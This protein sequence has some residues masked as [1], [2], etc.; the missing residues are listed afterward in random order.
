[1]NAMELN[2]APLQS[3]SVRTAPNGPS[4][5]EVHGFRERAI[6]NGYP[7]IRVRSHSKAPY[8]QNWRRGESPEALS[9]VQP[10]AANTGLVLSGYRCIDC[11]IDDSQL[12]LETIRA[13]R[14][15]LPCG[16]I[17]RRRANSPRMALLYRAAEGQPC[18]RMVKGPKG[19]IEILGLGQQVVVHGL[20]PSGAVIAWQNGRGPD[21]VP[22]D[23]VPAVSEQQ[24]T[25]FLSAC[26]PLLGAT[27][28]EAE[29][30]GTVNAF[31]LELPPQF[32]KFSD[33]FKHVPAENDLAAG[34]E[35]PNW[36]SALHPGEKSALVQACLNALDNRTNDPRDRWLTA[37]FAAADAE[38][39]GCSDARQLA[40]DWSQRGA[41]WTNEA[42]FETAWAS[43]K[44]KP[45]GVTIGSLLGMAAD[46]GLDLSPWRDAALAR[47][48]GTSGEAPGQAVQ[49][50]PS[51]TP[52]DSHGFLTIDPDHMP[53]HRQWSISTKLING[54][55]TVLAAKGGWGKSAYSI[56]MA[57]SAASGRDFL[58]QKVWGGAKRVVYINSEDDTDELQR[59]F[60]AAARHHQLAKPDLA[61]IMVRGVNTP[62]HET[63]TIGDESAP[64]VNDI[65]FTALE[66]IITKAEPDIV[67]LDPL[68]TFC[69]AGLNHNGV[70]SQVLL[71]LKRLAK[72]HGCAMLV[73]H[74]TRK[75]TDLTNIDAIGGA[76][77][78]VN[79]ARVAIMIARMTPEEAKNFKGILPSELWR[80]FRLVD[81]KTNLAPPSSHTQW[82]QFVSH[83]LPNAEPPTYCQGDGVQVVDKVDPNQLKASPVAS[84]TDNA[85]KRAILKAAHAADPPLSPSSK[86]GSDRYIVRR[87]LDPVRQATGMYWGDRDLTKHV[88]SLVQEMMNVGW[89]RVEE[90]KVGRNTR[91]G[92][93]VDPARTPWAHEFTGTGHGSTQPVTQH[94]HQMHQMPIETIDANEAGD[95]DARRTEGASNVLKG[96]GDLTRRIFDA[97]PSTS[98]SANSAEAPLVSPAGIGVVAELPAVSEGPARAP[99]A[100]TRTNAA[101]PV[102]TFDDY[103]DLPDF[104][105]RRKYKPTTTDA[106]AAS[107]PDSREI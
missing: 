9:V 78:I 62:G 22:H 61:R 87:V 16:A 41:S 13:A 63:L 107:G 44:L 100:P 77:A 94:P 34:I 103:P 64:R 36:F 81:A 3:V 83:E 70:M 53:P 19:K 59:R 6:G 75:D 93:V 39:L 30:N 49:A 80:Y 104:L 102:Q 66:A 101:P 10:E 38:G 27:I 50:A 14:K 26:A 99:A 92:L 98:P 8:A 85:A 32:G 105:D 86:G 74:H 96:Y 20:H 84:V 15:H 11:D 67:I 65:G 69:P 17:I 60:I 58:E 4:V 46:G 24:I 91:R 2:S 72:K 89:L 76:S 71:R 68:G 35:S 23:Q 47:L 82:Y 45:G 97:A 28:P 1:V 43:Y 56:S 51:G 42:D 40:L 55:V 73:V 5:D 54:E 12:V 95:I 37:L 18:K 25:A 106:A 57:C 7:V 48:R 21:T 31:G 79:Q 52:I 29:I 88:E 90:V 33:R